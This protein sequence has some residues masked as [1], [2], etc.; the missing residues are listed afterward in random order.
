MPTPIGYTTRSQVE[1]FLN[2]TFSEVDTNEFN[3]YIC[4]AE[5]F[6][7]NFTGYNAQTTYSGMQAENVVREKTIGKIDNYNNLVIDVMKP[8]V[9][10]DANGN[11]LVTLIEFNNGG[12]RVSLNLTDNSTNA[13]NTVLE[14]SENR[15]KII[16]PSMYFLPVMTNVTPTAKVNLYALKDIKF[17]VDVSYTGGFYT[18]PSD[19]TAAANYLV[20]DML[21]NRD[22]P[23]TASEIRQGSY[24]VRFDDTKVTPNSEMAKKLLE[25]YVRYTW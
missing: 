11:P 6:I 3:D 4:Q 19:I 23:N 21:Q 25:P 1:K 16:Y 22:N 12:V 10:F 9:Q 17:W 2:R 18:I 13:L 8:P 24:M 14:V 7:N 20:I 15:K 5:A